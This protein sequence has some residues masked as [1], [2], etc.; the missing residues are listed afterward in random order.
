M[1]IISMNNVIDNIYCNYYTRFVKPLT[2]IAQEITHW[3][4]T[5]F[6]EVVNS[7]LPSYLPL[8]SS[9]A[10]VR[11]KVTARLIRHYNTQ[12]M[13]DEPDKE[14]REARYSYRHLLQ[15]LV[16]RRL[17]ADGYASHVIGDLATSKSNE[18]LEALLQGGVQLEIKI[19]N[20]ALAFLHQIQEREPTDKS[21]FKF[22][23]SGTKPAPPP[24]TESSH[25]QRVEIIPGFEIHI[26]S[27]F[28]YPNSSHEEQMLW[29][30]I[31]ETLQKFAQQRRSS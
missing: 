25:W 1:S 23:R 26:R 3:S 5:E 18:E 7:Y 11:D 29:Q 21:G 6:V 9:S 2:E 8:D 28:P 27:D 15:I 22:K 30:H 31:Q 14:G 24:P 13:L 16:V 12:N 19:A 4:L 10:K 20:P 17:L